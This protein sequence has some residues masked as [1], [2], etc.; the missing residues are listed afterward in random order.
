M[1]RSAIAQASWIVPAVAFAMNAVQARQ[2]SGHSEY[3][4]G[5]A[6]GSS[7]VAFAAYVLG[8][9]L[10]IIALRSRDKRE[11]EKKLPSNVKVPALV[12]LILNGVALTLMIV[13]IIVVLGSD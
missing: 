4:R 3:D 2:F 5:Y 11:G 12:G 7:C 9:V 13:T 6:Q 1:S 8:L 10:A